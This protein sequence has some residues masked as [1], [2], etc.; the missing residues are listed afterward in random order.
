VLGLD[1]CTTPE[2]EVIRGAQRRLRRRVR[3]K[4]DEH[5]DILGS[6]R[7]E[8][9]DCPN[10]PAEGIVVHH[11]GSPKRLQFGKDLLD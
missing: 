1:P 6:C 3:S 2:E 8:I 4:D 10:R 5:V 11:T 7:L 9:A